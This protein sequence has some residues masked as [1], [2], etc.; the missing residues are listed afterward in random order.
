MTTRAAD[1]GFYVPLFALYTAA[2]TLA[3]D[4]E[5]PEGA[6]GALVGLGLVLAAMGK[7]AQAPLHT[8]LAGAMAGPTPV[9]ALLHSATMVAAGVYLLIRSQ[10]LLQGWP[11]ELAG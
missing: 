11:L 5:R 6:L 1:F 3:F 4:S 8:W 7:S 2:G 10:A 9:S